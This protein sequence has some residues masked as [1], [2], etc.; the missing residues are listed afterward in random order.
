MRLAG[1]LYKTEPLDGLSALVHLNAEHEIYRAHFPGSP[2]TPGVCI[3]QMAVEIFRDLSDKQLKVTEVR[4]AKFLSPVVPGQS[5][6]RFD[7]EPVRTP[8]CTAETGEPCAASLRLNVSVSDC[9]SGAKVAKITV[10]GE[11]YNK[12]VVSSY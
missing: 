7:F 2:I 8:L 5:A 9:V 10:L 4:D 12:Q 6:L 11:L 1:Q 3:I